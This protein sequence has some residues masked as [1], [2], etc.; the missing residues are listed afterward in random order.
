MGADD[1]AREWLYELRARGVNGSLLQDACSAD[2]K[3]VR[4]SYGYLPHRVAQAGEKYGLLAAK[5]DEEV[6]EVKAAHIGSPDFIEELGDLIEVC[7]ALGGEERVEAARLAKKEKRGGFD[8]LLV[9]KV[10]DRTD[11]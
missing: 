8:R 2:E 4:D 7:Y 11:K 5:F 1:A 6:A 3:L 10:A 9:M